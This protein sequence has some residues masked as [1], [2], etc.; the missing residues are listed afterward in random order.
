MDNKEKKVRD[1]LKEEAEKAINDSARITAI[2]EKAAADAEANAK[3]LEENKELKAQ[4]DALQDKKLTLKQNTGTKNY[5]FK[6]Y[7]VSRPARNFTMDIP[8]SV[9]DEGAANMLNM[10]RAASNKDVDKALTSTGAYA[11]GEEY[12]SAIMGLAELS[13]VVLA[14]C[15]VLQVSAPVLKLPSKATRAGV[16]MQAFG[17]TN[18][19][20][21]TDLG[22]ITWTIDKRIGSYETLYNDI[23]DDQIFDIVGQFVEPMIA[24]AIG[25]SVD[26]NVFND[27]DTGEFTTTL[28]NGATTYTTTSGTVAT[29]AGITFDN[30]NTIYNTI[31]WSRGAV[32]EWFMGQ[33]A[34]KDVMGL[35][36]TYG[37]PVHQAVPIGGAPQYSIFGSRVNITPAIAN[38][39]N[40]DKLRLAFG[41]PRQYV[42]ALRG[43]IVFQVNPYVGLKEGYSQYIGF[44]RADGNVTAPSAWS[45]LKRVDA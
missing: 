7:D 20:A 35:V 32:G 5:I 30:L 23:L 25:Q 41:D 38:V 2:E 39:P 26:D 11:V 16:D 3:L 8:K 10:L 6:G 1:M 24:E 22:Q 28:D 34:F 14:R 42:L 27:G 33:S 21:A 44:L 43:G 45:G 18:Q 13:S 17:T 31:E 19:A 12:G 37:Q 15:K 9:R 29:A 40:A 4:F 36:D